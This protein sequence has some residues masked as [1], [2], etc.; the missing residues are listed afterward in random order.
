[1]LA[2]K[3]LVSGASVRFEG[4][5]TVYHY[6]GGPCY[7]CLH[8]L[9]PPAETVTNCA[10]GGVMG[11]VPGIIGSMQA[12][13]AQKILMEMDADTQVLSKRMVLFDA[14]TCTFRNAK[15]RGR[16]AKCAICGDAPTIT[17]LIPIG[18][19]SCAPA[20]AAPHPQT[21][22]DS[23]NRVTVQQYKQVLESKEKHIL[24]DVRDEHQYDICHVPGATSMQLLLIFIF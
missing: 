15:L 11:V 5:L 16:Q 17:S 18:A 4:Q 24:I 2:N 3:P 23:K 19:A 22:L 14:K 9:P 6:K 7:R 1:M 21:T 8:P 10:D 13:E 12:L 20:T